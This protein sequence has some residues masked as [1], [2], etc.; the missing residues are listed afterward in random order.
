M[1]TSLCKKM[2]HKLETAADKRMMLQ[3]MGTFTFRR[4]QMMNS[5][6]KIDIHGALLRFILVLMKGKCS[7]CE[8][9]CAPS[10]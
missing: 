4:H 1:Y 3:K 10:T 8:S 2:M 9:K 6:P 7:G 5:V